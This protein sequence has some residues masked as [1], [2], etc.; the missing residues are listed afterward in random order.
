LKANS[1]PPGAAIPTWRHG[2]FL[3]LI[4]ILF[5]LPQI[6]LVPLMDRDEP[7]FAEASR[8]ML[9]SGDII[10][11]T[12]NH[13]PRYN[14]P[15]LIYWCQATSFAV[16]GENAF[17]ARLPSVLATAGTVFLLFAWGMQLGSGCLGMI[18]GCCYAFNL[19][20][21]QQGRVATA[22]ALLIFFMT[23]TAYTGWRLLDHRSP[24]KD[25]PLPKS[26]FRTGSALRAWTFRLVLA[27]AAGFLAK[28]PEA[29]L[30]LVPLLTFARP[31]RGQVYFLLCFIFSVMLVCIW[32]VPALIASQGD[33]WKQGMSEGVFTRMTTGL[34][35]HGAST[36]GW[37]LLS[38]PLYVVL[39]WVS[40][41]PWSPLLVT[42][43]KKLFTGWK[44][45]RLDAYLLLNIVLIFVIF[46][47]MV[48]KLPHYTLPAFP[49]IA[50]LFARRWIAAGLS[51][52]LPTQLT[53]VFALALALA[54]AG[55]APFAPTLGLSPSPLNQ[56][57]REAG[58]AIKPDTEFALGDSQEPSTIWEMRRAT[59]A[60]GHVIP[61][62]DAIAYLSQPGSRAVVFSSAIENGPRRYIIDDHPALPPG[63]SSLKIY[64]TQG[65]N[66]AKGSRIGLTLLVKP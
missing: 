47:L 45:D 27:L 12:F 38:V 11:P 3:V 65:I 10:V 61:T 55:F 66:S 29:W 32:G 34:Q 36:F 63:L 26:I 37:Y 56:L 51:P 23:L 9:Q 14:K 25:H 58:D 20:V 54:T 30:P 42:H 13:V 21:F 19:Q 18:A 31:W 46:S 59:Q 35:G 24:P 49:F 39:F 1:S 43:G 40:A 60:Y 22:D 28:G 8:E 48:T 41:L 52:V 15:P 6:A 16:F 17:A 2:L 57:V 53:G 44:L 50:L 64:H 4:V 7:R 5:S 62:S 33:Y